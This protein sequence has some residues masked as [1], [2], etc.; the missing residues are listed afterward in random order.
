LDHR[1]VIWQKLSTEWKFDQLETIYQETVL[2]D[3]NPYIDKI[4]K[5]G[6]TGRIVVNA[7]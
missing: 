5:G 6:I 4:L 2:A 3:L 7:E 1:T